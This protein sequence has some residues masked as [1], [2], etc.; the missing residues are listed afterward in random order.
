[1]RLIKT[2]LVAGLLTAG[3]AA[4]ADYYDQPGY[5]Y[6]YGYDTGYHHYSYWRDGRRYCRS[7]SDPDAYY[8]CDPY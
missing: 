1:M 8:R 3:L 6:D 4:C 7:D 2:L 5:G